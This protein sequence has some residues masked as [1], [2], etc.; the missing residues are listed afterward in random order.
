[1]GKFKEFEGMLKKK[2]YSGSS[3]AK[4]AAWAGNHKYGKSV[5]QEAARKGVSAAS[6]KKKREK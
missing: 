2:G 1:M 6:V 3:A 5:M 4:I